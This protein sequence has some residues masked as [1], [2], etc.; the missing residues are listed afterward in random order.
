MKRA[1]QNQGSRPP[2]Q[3]GAERR[4]AGGCGWFAA[5]SYFA[6]PV[7]ATFGRPPNLAG[8]PHFGRPKVAPTS[9]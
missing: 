5:L 8:L 3:G 2:F 9:V 6:R 4:E 1:S 7:G